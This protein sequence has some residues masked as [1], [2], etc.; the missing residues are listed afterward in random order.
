MLNET[1]LANLT[2]DTPCYETL[3]VTGCTVSQ[4]RNNRTG[5]DG[6]VIQFINFTLDDGTM[7]RK[8]LNGGS[9]T[10]AK[11]LAETY[12]FAGGD[13]KA[14]LRN[15]KSAIGHQVCV[16]HAMNVEG[17]LQRPEWVHPL[18]EHS[19]EAV[20]SVLARVDALDA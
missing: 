16:K 14:F 7:V 10:V 9:L 5:K 2:S 18:P 17:V 4:D 19:E 8:N 3:K 12:G 11:D 6:G 20:D 13:F 15:P 1:Q